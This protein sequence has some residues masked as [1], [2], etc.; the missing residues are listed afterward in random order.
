M[1]IAKIKNAN[2]AG[3]TILF[4]KQQLIKIHK[5]KQFFPG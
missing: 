1:E 3:L 2:E 4:M 5:M